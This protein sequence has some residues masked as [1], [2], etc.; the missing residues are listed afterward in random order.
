MGR[1][2]GQKHSVSFSIS[3]LFPHWTF[4]AT[5]VCFYSSLQ[6]KNKK[7]MVLTKIS[8]HFSFSL[9]L[10]AMF[11]ISPLSYFMTCSHFPFTGSL[12]LAS[13]LGS[14]HLEISMWHLLAISIIFSYPY[15]TGEKEQFLKSASCTPLSAKFCLLSLYPNPFN[16][17]FAAAV[18]VFIPSLTL[19][20]LLVQW[21]CLLVQL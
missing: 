8:F 10:L 19:C 18:W 1:E 16:T 21:D 5:P 7:P 9:F 14:Q 20:L 2:N 12:V 11:H 4:G 13:S 17:T 3:L 15:P 6:K